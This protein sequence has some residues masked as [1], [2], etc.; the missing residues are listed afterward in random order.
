MFM[1]KLKYII[2]ILI[3]SPIVF[4]MGES[5]FHFTT[6]DISNK[7]ASCT[8]DIDSVITDKDEISDLFE[9]LNEA[10]MQTG[11]TP[12][13]IEYTYP[14]AIE[15]AIIVYCNPEDES[16]IKEQMDLKSYSYKSILSGTMNIEF[17]NINKISILRNGTWIQFLGDQSSCSDS[18]KLLSQK[19]SLRSQS[20][21]QYNS[22]PIKFIY[23][24]YIIT[25][26]IIFILGIFDV[27]NQKKEYVVRVTSGTNKLVI[28]VKN[29]VI[30]SLVYI[31]IILISTLICTRINNVT[32]LA[33]KIIVLS[34]IAVVS[35]ILP[36][37]ALV[38]CN[39][40]AVIRGK[41]S[42]KAAL[43]LA[44]IINCVVIIVLVI[45]I[46]ATYN[47]IDKNSGYINAKS[48]FENEGYS[49]CDFEMFMDASTLVEK[50]RAYVNNNEEIYR[51]YYQEC[52]PIMLSGIYLGEDNNDNI[53]TNAI[54]ANSNAAEYIC[55][56][57]DGLEL[58]D[59]GDEYTIIYYKNGNER[60]IADKALEV[61]TN[62]ECVDDN[63]N[64]DFNYKTIS[65]DK[66][67]KS[68]AMNSNYDNYFEQL[69]DPII[70]I[71]NIPANE[72]K[73]T[74]EQA[75]RA[76]HYNKIMY[77]AYDGFVDE[78]QAKYNFDRNIITDCLTQYNYYWSINKIA[79]MFLI[80]F[81]IIM[82][83]VE[84]L[85]NIFIL[86]SY[87]EINGIEICLKKINGYT[88]VKRYADI[89]FNRVAYVLL[90]LLVGIIVLIYYG[91]VQW[92]VVVII[93]LC[94]L[95]VDLLVLF[96]NT[97]R[98][99]IKNMSQIIKGGAL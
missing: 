36:Y 72:M 78:V 31:L 82:M 44:N 12:F 21:G 65:L 33:D 13:F 41:N 90:G 76:A 6:N 18:I 80:S 73:T 55:S 10:K 86:R 37:T 99:E 19:Y 23:A 16:L 67:Y 91:I 79:I 46:S 62:T 94:L 38:F 26:I 40:S 9:L 88:Y 66:H 48:L 39:Y 20:A 45:V 95:A 74:I 59:L 77:K 54:Y 27:E 32:E 52:K 89:L 97:Q 61:I 71:N 2:I 42:K 5:A 53:R 43:V 47:R 98:I 87:F 93:S 29:I 34:I 15:T 7:F 92:Y 81:S 1:K 70:I 68:I 50:H 49:F 60:D 56:W 14:S 24:A 84:L 96:L 58:S 4:F 22:S 64:Y 69:D 25:A 28:I 17:E 30:D 3:L 8:L 11:S 85:L 51:D 63:C 57:I 35:N 83:I 75:N